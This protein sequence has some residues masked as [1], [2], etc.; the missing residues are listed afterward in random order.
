MGAH[1]LRVRARLDGGVD[2]T[3]A[4]HSWTVTPPAPTTSAPAVPAPAAPDRIGPVL[5]SL[6]LVVGRITH[7]L[8]ETARVRFALER[9]ARRSGRFVALPQTFLH[10]GA[11][12]RNQLRLAGRLRGRAVRPGRYRLTATAIDAAGNHSRPAR[13]HFAIRPIG[14]R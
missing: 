13:V 3:P 14:S 11:A 2:P 8:S 10:R 5:R 12:G 4:V 6:G 9:R 7:T 1:T